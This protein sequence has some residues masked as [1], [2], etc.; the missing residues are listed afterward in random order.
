V[1]SWLR[2]GGIVVVAVPNLASGQARIAGRSWHHL[3]LPRH[4]THLTARGLGRM[5]ERHGLELRRLSHRVPE[6]NPGGMW[7]A[8]LARLGMTPSFPFHLLKRNA[9]PRAKDVA[10]T[11]LGVPL[12]P[13]AVAAEWLA[14]LAH[15]GGSLVAVASRE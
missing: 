6:H 1:A 2:P 12:L 13:L 3:D 10:L 11:V 9:R 15:R 7:M 14:Q 5:L 8:L 4:R